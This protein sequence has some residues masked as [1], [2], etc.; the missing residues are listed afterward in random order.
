MASINCGRDAA[1]SHARG[2]CGGVTSADSLQHAVH[3]ART[4]SGA[5]P[6]VLRAA[7]LHEEAGSD[8]E[9]SMHPRVQAVRA[10]L[11]RLMAE[12]QPQAPYEGGGVT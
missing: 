5:T 1:E 11:T 12:R 9:P 10:R 8:A 3:V 2:C 4:E 6:A 7:E